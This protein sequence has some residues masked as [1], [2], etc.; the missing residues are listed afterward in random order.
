MLR[1]YSTADLLPIDPGAWSDEAGT[2]AYRAPEQVA[3]CTCTHMYMHTLCTYTRCAYA[4]RS[5]WRCRR[6]TCTAYTC[7][8]STHIHIHSWQVALPAGDV[9]SASWRWVG[10]W[11]IDLD[12]GG[13][14]ADGWQYAINWG[15]RPLV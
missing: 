7:T 8:Y 15:T 14:G 12:G 13:K 2:V 1:D 9:H 5:R 6:A 4:R 10:D 11:K 3:L